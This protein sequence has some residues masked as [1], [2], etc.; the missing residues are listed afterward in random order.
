MKNKYQKYIE[1]S[2]TIVLIFL[3]GNVARSEDLQ[4]KDVCSSRNDKCD[5][6]LYTSKIISPTYNTEKNDEKVIENLKDLG[7]SNGSGI[8]V[9]NSTN[10]E[11]KPV[12]VD[13][14]AIIA[15][16]VIDGKTYYLISFRGTDSDRDK[17]TDTVGGLKTQKLANGSEVHLGFYDYTNAVYKSPK[18]EAMLD[19]IKKTPGGQYE[20]LLT[21]HSLGG[22]A[23]QVMSYFLKENNDLSANKIKT[24]VFG[25]PAPGN[26]DFS[27]RY[28]K[29]VIRAEIDIDGV[30][31][32]RNPIYTNVDY[33]TKVHLPANG[34]TKSRLYSLLK[35]IDDAPL[36]KRLWVTKEVA[37]E[38]AGLLAE[39]H[40]QYGDRIESIYDGFR[41]AGIQNNN[42]LIDMNMIN[43]CYTSQGSS[44][45]TSAACYLSRA[46][47]ENLYFS[48]IKDS[49]PENLQQKS[50]YTDGTIVKAPIDIG[51]EWN[52]ST[53]L[54]LDSH[55][56]TPSGDH[57]YFSQRGS[58][59]NAPN[60]FLYRD[61]IPAAGKLGA[62]QTRITTFQEGD[63]RFYIYN[64]S[65]QQNLAPAGL[66]NSSA[67]VQ[68]F[69]GGGLLSDIPNDPNVFDLN[70]PKL[71]KVGQ[72]Y[73]G[74]NT[75]NVPTGQ[76]GNAWYV[77]K[78]NTRTG[79]L[80]RVDRFSNVDSSS[81]VPKFK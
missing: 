78:L 74:T 59:T 16:K 18:F 81:N 9:K 51:L 62:E 64:F 40:G 38:I 21:G 68:L 36:W 43:S 75:F 6:I 34:E 37:P 52:Q 14:Q 63:Y 30:P 50:Q 69:Q 17:L 12:D 5:A 55:T 11:G 22:A 29:D 58:L 57:V 71:Q 67:K 77:F 7:W 70:D 65:D 19:E 47:Y 56:V 28:L 73:P 42:P 8:D 23:A 49:L 15:K 10:S 66:S 53:K 4:L 27:D 46:P 48:E 31:Y 35:K 33:G 76:S 20:I 39:A 60:T 41:I 25:S 61:S 1:F 79:I 2:A 54:D 45:I 3:S 72:P 80:N 24:V 32:A 44:H 13:A 26:K